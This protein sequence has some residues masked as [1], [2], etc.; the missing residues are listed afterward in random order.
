MP[1][2]HSALPTILLALNADAPEGLQQ[3]TANYWAMSHVDERTGQIKFRG[4]TDALNFRAWSGTVHF[5]AGAGGTATLD[6]ASCASCG[7]PLTLT[8]RKG[9][10]DAFRGEPV[11]CRAC[12]GSV[13]A[14]AVKILDPATIV[15]RQAK[16]DAAAVRRTQLL[17]EQETRQRRLANADVLEQQRRDVIADRYAEVID[18]G[19]GLQDAEVV[20]R[21]TAL[22]LIHTYE[23]PDGLLRHDN[24]TTLL[25]PDEHSAVQIAFYSGLL[26]VH[27][28]SPT[29][30]FEWVDEYSAELTGSL[31]LLRAA[32]TVPGTGRLTERLATFT[33]RLRNSLTIDTM[34]S[35]ERAE[36]VNLA[37]RLIAGETERYFRYKLDEH[38]FL[39]AITD[40]HRERLR[41]LAHTASRHFALGHIYNMLYMCS[42]DVASAHD[43]HAGM[44]REKAITYGL[45]QFDRWI[46]RGLES[47]DSL[48]YYSEHTNVLPLTELTSLLFRTVLGVDPMQ[49]NSA[50][51]REELAHAPDAELRERCDAGIPEPT[52]Q[53]E[54]LRTSLGPWNIDEFRSNLAL[55]QD[56]TPDL[57]APHCAH[58]NVAA[59]AAEA[60]AFYDR[61][62]ARAGA[63]DAAIITAEATR[64]GNVNSDAART[65]DA[66][67]S[68]LVR[69]LQARSV[70]A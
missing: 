45:N 30:A 70:V 33:T 29:A 51:I 59:V 39:N 65:G 18:E 68:E 13:D 22:A 14:H 60:G 5:A 53:I 63:I 40:Q 43:R 36:V 11:R 54:W 26:C 69:L 61:I 12:D 4:T 16:A 27:P 66:V 35:T 9:L 67:L 25:A 28:A 47:T 57:C 34:W 2:A 32:F 3:L 19:C 44:S 38:H 24:A 64:I 1:T 15:H 7:K 56:W 8:S 48:K 10:N 20:D 42:R 37:E 58:E 31:Y 52:E 55:L 17:A 23:S 46:Q 50:A 62:V 41:T 6:G 49:T 21:I